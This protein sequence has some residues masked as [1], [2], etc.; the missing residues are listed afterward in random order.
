MGL[1][2]KLIVSLWYCKPPAKLSFNQINSI[3]K[4]L[5][6]QSSNIPLEF[7]KNVA[8]YWTPK[9]GKPQS[10]DSFCYILAL[11]YYLTT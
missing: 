5:L 9:D 11:L 4:K 3:S 8:Q 1:V 7:S 10:L 2:K 6:N